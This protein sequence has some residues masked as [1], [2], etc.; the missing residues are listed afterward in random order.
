MGAKTD[1]EDHRIVLAEKR[2]VVLAEEQWRE[3]IY[4][5]ELFFSYTLIA[6]YK[7]R[8]D[9]QVPFLGYLYKICMQPQCQL[10]CSFTLFRHFKWGTRKNELQRI[11]K[12]KWNKVK[13]NKRHEQ[14]ASHYSPLG[15]LSS[16]C[17][18]KWESFFFSLTVLTFDTI[19]TLHYIDGF[20]QQKNVDVLKM[21]ITVK[22][23]SHWPLFSKAKY[24]QFQ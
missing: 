14:R 18:N 5:S 7:K 12:K 13:W 17:G 22:V 11:S 3:E 10:L 19:I 9:T 23:R 6:T 2:R 1:M 20:H 21:N 4:Y 16:G 15:F 8:D 24:S